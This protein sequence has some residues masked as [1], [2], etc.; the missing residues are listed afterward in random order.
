M[1]RKSHMWV[2]LSEV[3]KRKTC[4]FYCL[5]QCYNTFNKCWTILEIPC[6]PPQRISAEP[7]ECWSITLWQTLS[8]HVSVWPR[9]S[10]SLVRPYTEKHKW[11]FGDTCPRHTVQTFISAN[12]VVSFPLS[13]NIC[14]VIHRGPTQKY[15][16][17][18]VTFKNTCRSYAFGTTGKLCSADYYKSHTSWKPGTPLFQWPESLGKWKIT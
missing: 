5:L 14:L 18:F 6:C 9:R 8:A 7:D 13:S 10:L 4:N 1:R 12:T 16:I 11:T 17:Q 3:V 15:Y 2:I